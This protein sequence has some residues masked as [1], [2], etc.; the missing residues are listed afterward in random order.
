MRLMICVRGGNNLF[1]FYRRLLLLL[2]IVCRGTFAVAQDGLT[3]STRPDPAQATWSVPV[4]TQSTEY[5]YQH[6]I[7]LAQ[8]ERWDEARRLL[9]A[10]SHLAPSD[11]RFPIELAGVAFKQKDKKR[12]IAYL[13]HALQLDPSDA[14]ANEFLATLY[15]LEGNLEAALK[16]WNAA[17]KP[18]IGQVRMEPAL[19]VRPGL[20]DHAFAFAPESVLTLDE[21]RATEARL[22]QLEIFAGNRVDLTAQGD[23]KFDAVFRAQELNGFGNGKLEA[24]VRLLR[25][26]PFQEVDPEYFNFHGAGVNLTSQFRWD[27]DKR[28]ASLE[29]SGPLVHDPRWRFEFQAGAREENWD[30]VTSFAGPAQLLGALNLRRE[31]FNAGVTRLIGA[32]WSW[33]VGAEVSH[34][35]FRDVFAGT[36]LTPQLVARGYQLKQTIKLR[37]DLWHSVEH[38]LTLS[39]GAGLQAARLWA[40]SPESF[41]RVLGSMETHWLPQARGDD[42]GTR[43]RLRAGKTFGQIPFDE[44]WMLGLE[45]DNDLWLRAHVGTRDGRKGSAPLGR[46]YF[47]S[48]WETDK[49][50]F[51]NGFL[52]LKLG[53]FVDTGSIR[54]TGSSLGSQ[55]WLWDTGAQAKLRLL[56]VGVTFSY[57]KDLRSGNNAFYTTLIRER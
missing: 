2:V 21:L 46:D 51:S 6:G 23:G 56:G 39:S 47:L 29:W 54:D 8:L 37:H 55:K 52:G 35:D 41:S 18:L 53:P 12:A 40:Q 33:S 13:R 25:G 1:H 19:R 17:G 31:E 34:R 45:R 15:F 11:K 36:A 32:R 49:N 50:V 10:G 16:Y 57:G 14:Y 4:S 44:L 20:L 7:A 42:L 30:L 24:A 27:P 3:S 9:L 26:L 48:N 28:R 22:S 43:W 5:D 38:R